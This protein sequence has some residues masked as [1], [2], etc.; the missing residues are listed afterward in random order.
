[1]Y[2]GKSMIIDVSIVRRR[3]AGITCTFLNSNRLVISEGGRNI[4]TSICITKLP[5]FH[6]M[7]NVKMT[8]LTN[9]TKTS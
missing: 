4:I 8:T 2:G 1:M 5:L 3:V 6:K 9:S 7:T